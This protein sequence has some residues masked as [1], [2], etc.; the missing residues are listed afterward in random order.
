M[1]KESHDGLVEIN[2][3]QVGIALVVMPDLIRRPGVFAVIFAGINVDPSAHF[4]YR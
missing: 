1:D 4:A 2:I 3:R